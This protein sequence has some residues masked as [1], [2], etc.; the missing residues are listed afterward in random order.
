MRQANNP[1]SDVK[2]CHVT[3][4]Y[5]NFSVGHSNLQPKIGQFVWAICLLHPL[6]PKGCTEQKYCNLA[7]E[8]IALNN[9]K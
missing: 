5:K 6:A 2:V 9:V 3:H 1:E 4:D 8:H 7:S